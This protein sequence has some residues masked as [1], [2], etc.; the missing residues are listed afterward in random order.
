MQAVSTE[1]GFSLKS[2]LMPHRSPVA[3]LS[4]QRA[5]R[6]EQEVGPTHEGRVVEGGGYLSK[7]RFPAHSDKQGLHE[8]LQTEVGGWLHAE[9]A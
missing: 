7:G 9:T 2:H 8:L 4:C 5:R 3:V 6:V 1:M